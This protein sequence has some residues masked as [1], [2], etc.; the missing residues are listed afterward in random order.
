MKLSEIT[1]L[2]VKPA[3]NPEDVLLVPEPPGEQKH[4]RDTATT[5]FGG[6]NW[7][8]RKTPENPKRKSPL[9]ET[10]RSLTKLENSHPK[11]GAKYSRSKSTPLNVVLGKSQGF[12]Q[13][14][15]A[16][17]RVSNGTSKNKAEETSVSILP[18]SV[19]KVATP[20]KT[21]HENFE[22]TVDCQ[23]G[24]TLHLKKNI[25]PGILPAKVPQ[26]E[27]SSVHLL[28]Q[29]CSPSMQ[30]PQK[31][32]EEPGEQL[33]NSPSH[34]AINTK[35]A[36]VVTGCLTSSVTV[37]EESITGKQISNQEKCVDINDWPHLETSKAGNQD[38]HSMN[39][40]PD[41]LKSLGDSQKNSCEPKECVLI[42]PPLKRLKFS[43]CRSTECT[44]KKTFKSS[45]LFDESKPGVVVDNRL[46]VGNKVFSPKYD[47]LAIESAPIHTVSSPPKIPKC[48]DI[49][50]S[51][52]LVY[53]PSVKASSIDVNKLEDSLERESICEDFDTNV[54]LTA[55]PSECSTIIDSEV[56]R[57][58]PLVCEIRGSSLL[59]YIV[60]QTQFSNTSVS[61][62]QALS[63]DSQQ[64]SSTRLSY[65]APQP[66]LP[67]SDKITA[68]TSLNFSSSGRYTENEN[69]KEGE[70]KNDYEKIN[71]EEDI[72]VKTPKSSRLQQ[73]KEVKDP[74]S[75]N[76]N[77]ILSTNPFV[78]LKSTN[79]FDYCKS[80]LENLELSKAEVP[81]ENLNKGVSSFEIGEFGECYVDKFKTVKNMELPSLE[82]DMDE[83]VKQPHLATNVTR[84]SDESPDKIPVSVTGCKISLGR[85]NTEESKGLGQ[86]DD[87]ET[88]PSVIMDQNLPD[89]PSVKTVSTLK[90][91][92]MT[93]EDQNICSQPSEPSVKYP[94]VSEIQKSSICPP[95]LKTN[96]NE[97]FPNGNI[98]LLLWQDDINSPESLRLLCESKSVKPQYINNPDESSVAGVTSPKIIEAQTC[99]QG[100]GD[101]MNTSNANCQSSN[102]FRILTPPKTNQKIAIEK[103]SL[104]NRKGKV[105]SDDIKRVSTNTTLTIQSSGEEALVI[106][107]PCKTVFSEEKCL[108]DVHDTTT[109]TKKNSGISTNVPKI[110]TKRR[111]NL[112]MHVF[113]KQDTKKPHSRKISTSHLQLTN[114]K[115]FQQDIN[116]YNHSNCYP[117]EVSKNFS[118]NVIE[119]E[120]PFVVEL[121]LCF[122]NLESTS[123]ECLNQCTISLVKALR[124]RMC[125]SKPYKITINEIIATEVHSS[126]KNLFL[127]SLK[128]FLS[129][130]AEAELLITE[131]QKRCFHEEL[132]NMME[133]NLQ[134][135]IKFHLEKVHVHSMQKTDLLGLEAGQNYSITFVS[136]CSKIFRGFAVVTNI[137]SSQTIWEQPNTVFSFLCFWLALFNMKKAFF[138]GMLIYNSEFPD[139]GAI[140][141]AIGVTLLLIS[142]SRYGI[143]FYLSRTNNELTLRLPATVFCLDQTLFVIGYASVTL[144]DI[145][146]ALNHWNTE[147]T[148]PDT[149]WYT[150]VQPSHS[151]N[152]NISRA[153]QFWPLIIYCWMTIILVGRRA[154]TVTVQ[155]FTVSI[156]FV[157][158]CAVFFPSSRDLLVWF[159]CT[160]LRF[161]IWTMLGLLG[162]SLKVIAVLMSMH[163]QIMGTLNHPSLKYIFYPYVII[164]LLGSLLNNLAFCMYTVSHLESDVAL[165]VHMLL[166]VFLF[167]SFD[168]LAF[169]GILLIFRLSDSVARRR[170]QI[171]NSSI[172]CDVVC[173]RGKLSPAREAAAVVIG[174]DNF[175]EVDDMYFPD[176]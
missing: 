91:F 13:Q 1:N 98:S 164:F 114:H 47:R 105:F 49:Q 23:P 135:K 141:N 77:S 127:L 140:L 161:N 95:D 44:A 22:L 110:L 56:E 103:V 165:C 68:I 34:K 117:L 115:C 139:Q 134:E 142:C 39:T 71:L 162:S 111:E 109:S 112:E 37:I 129:Y 113:K 78:T 82:I 102:I 159:V 167:L 70:L 26:T 130:N 90:L 170:F 17:L 108:N 137:V 24:N 60:D 55:I 156:S 87:L 81:A 171:K 73:A 86:V 138:Y 52:P 64:L 57:A 25:S 92:T 148:L 80:P 10:S 84:I 50:N 154:R 21:E 147:N 151:A 69:E 18:V 93:E 175:E 116:V 7:F 163:V 63:V 76:A 48:I 122:R 168:F 158:Q 144:G 58:G 79:P 121:R 157:F 133:E 20:K 11:K 8:S 94:L 136:T 19:V 83:T 61:S 146:L 172:T 31:S 149:H 125:S 104:I 97:A 152:I 145:Y 160:S 120:N 126:D 131:I 66:D 119:K 88:L 166:D 155:W 128:I 35:N 41:L 101:G 43:D 42:T 53:S 9:L 30:I 75:E 2:P 72:V 16:S 176:I 67:Q 100:E 5:F 14:P 173:K 12:I 62:P 74:T 65:E 46:V 143:F 32:D 33:S 15:K 85:E 118:F 96:L 89:D 3:L 51:S 169:A 174:I 54:N 29:C 150:L 123:E 106:G 6:R 107:S 124:S 45:I 40:L 59:E 28:K 153:I 99:S 132:Q 36:N 38:S 27:T 4:W